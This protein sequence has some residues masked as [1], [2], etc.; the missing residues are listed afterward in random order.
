MALPPLP[1]ADARD[2][3]RF[4]DAIWAEHGLARP[5]LDSYRRDLEGFARWLRGAG[6]RPVRGRPRRAVRLSRMACAAA[7][8]R[9][10][11]TRAC[12]RRC[13]RSTRWLRAPRRARRTT[14]PRCCD[15]PKLPRSL[16][17]A[18]AESEIEALLAAPDDRHAAGPARPRDARAD[19]RRRPARQRAGGPAGHRGQ[20]APGR[21]ARDRQGRQGAAGA[22]GRGGAALAGAL[23]RARRA[24]Y[25]RA[26]A[27][28]AAAVPDADGRGADAGSSSGRW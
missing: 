20:P 7:A 23:P 2:I 19:V 15:P 8:T 11:A 10:A 5:T 17:K 16:P 26:S 9:R 1:D 3:A 14:R 25:W 22:A 13:A 24:R 6:V 12:C 28:L 27:A 21:A 18:L 4:L